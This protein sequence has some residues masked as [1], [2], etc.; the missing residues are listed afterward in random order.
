MATKKVDPRKV[1]TELTTEFVK[2]L[3]VTA[4]VSVTETQEEAG[5]SYLVSLQGEDL[6]ILIG[7]HGETLN[8]LQ[9]LISLIASKKL[10]QWTR[11]TLDAG[12][13]RAK[14]GETL[15]DMAL[16]AA[17]KVVTNREE[18]ALPVMSSSDRRLVHLALQDN[19]N[20]ITESVGEEGYRRVV[21]KPRP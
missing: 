3:G 5:P 7:Y 21:L 14:R 1:I 11:L 8:A 19:A 20:I 13:W 6:G 12:D 4:E 16:R 15:A 10:D 9:L 2:D 17:E 18:V